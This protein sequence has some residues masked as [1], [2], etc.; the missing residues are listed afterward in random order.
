MLSR[1]ADSLYWM[2]RYIERAEDIARILD[3]NMQLLLD[4]PK[5]TEKQMDHLWEPVLY[6]TGDEDDFPKYYKEVT[7][8]NVI[9]FLAFNTKNQNSILFCITAA[10]EN[11]RQVREQIS[12]EM[13]EEINR[14]YLSLKDMN[15]RKLNKVGPAE[16]FG[17]IKLSC[18]LIQGITDATMTHGEGWDFIQVGKYIERADKTTRIIDVKHESL[19][20]KA[21][22]AENTMDALQW[23]AVLKSC[24]AHEAYRKIYV[25]Q[26]DPKKVVE[27]LALNDEFPRSIRFCCQE[28][29]RA[30]RRISGARDDEYT[31]L[32]EK[33]SGRLV[34]E[35]RYSGVDDIFQRGLHAYMDDLQQ[36][37]NEI[38]DVIFQS[39]MFYRGQDLEE[40]IRLQQCGA[41]Q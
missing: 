13:W 41:Q 30:L 20:A 31:N 33:R 1:V 21:T 37:L 16:F 28:L 35:L 7:R 34:S 5:K 17:Q 4:F 11:A 32:A 22:A 38:G 23:T 36:R 29:D 10:R 3:V 18:H 24:S 15:L 14:F 12:S 9:D 40:E 2:S 39:Y 26:V 27:F 8:E 6:S 25:A 19:S